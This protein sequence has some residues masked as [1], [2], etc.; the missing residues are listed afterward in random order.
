METLF[1]VLA[2]INLN[3]YYQLGISKDYYT[4]KL[5]ESEEEE[6][7]KGY[8]DYYKQK[9]VNKNDAFLLPQKLFDMESKLTYEQIQTMR[10]AAL[11]QLD[12]V[13][14]INELE[15]QI[16]TEEGRWFGYDEVKIEEL[17]KELEKIKEKQKKSNIK[18]TIAKK[19]SNAEVDEYFDLPDEYV[20]Y[21]VSFEI[22]N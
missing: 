10:S 13:K 18:E 21:H 2:Y 6:Y 22:P 11:T 16:K 9:Y 14:K 17:K 1:K 12:Y 5:T 15:A 20:I 3:F 7:I 19:E 4:K 8:L